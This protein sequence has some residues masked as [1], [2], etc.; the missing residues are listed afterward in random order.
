MHATWNE[1]YRGILSHSPFCRTGTNRIG[2]CV[3]VVLLD[4]SLYYTPCLVGPQSAKTVLHTGCT[5]RYFL[6][7]HALVGPQSAKTCKRPRGTAFCKNLSL[8]IVLIVSFQTIERTRPNIAVIKVNYDE[9]IQ[10]QSFACLLALIH[11]PDWSLPRQRQR[12]IGGHGCCSVWNGT[13]TTT[14]FPF[15]NKDIQCSQLSLLHGPA[16]RSFA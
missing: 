2:Y 10:K 12:P 8:Q 1:G 5:A 15:G 7:L 6:V 11:D 9:D 14:R 13:C 3:P 16:M 4:I